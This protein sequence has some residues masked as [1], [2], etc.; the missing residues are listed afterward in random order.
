MT[1][2]QIKA[3]RDLAYAQ[4]MMHLDS[5]DGLKAT[6]MFHLLVALEKATVTPGVA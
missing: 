5:G 4:M 6:D 3:A 2:E 1:S